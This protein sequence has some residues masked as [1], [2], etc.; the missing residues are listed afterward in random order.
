MTEKMTDDQREAL[1]KLRNLHTRSIDYQ[2]DLIAKA[3]K[4][5][6]RQNVAIA[7]FQAKITKDEAALAELDQQY[8]SALSDY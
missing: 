2:R 4:E 5:I 7:S 1:A 8:G 6:S 3:R